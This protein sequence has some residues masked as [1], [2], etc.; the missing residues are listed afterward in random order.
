MD[1]QFY[2]VID[3]QYTGPF[4]MLLLMRKARKGELTPDTLL[5]ASKYETPH[6]ASDIPTINVFFSKQQEAPPPSVAPHQP[7]T[8]PIRLFPL[9]SKGANELSF[10]QSTA[11]FFAILLILVAG[12]LALFSQ[13]LAASPLLCFIS[14][15]TLT[16]IMFLCAIAL[17]QVRRHPTGIEYLNTVLGAFTRPYLIASFVIGTVSLSLPLI[18]ATAINPIFAIFVFLLSP[19]LAMHSFAPFYIVDHPELTPFEAMQRSRDAVSHAGT[20]SLISLSV[21]WAMIS[22]AYGT[23]ILG[24][25]FIPIA[26]TAL[27]EYYEENLAA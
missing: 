8:P 6:K 16:S 12:F 3:D 18:L 4:D 20:L 10:H 27:A 7:A 9:L 17:R 26:M 15:F 19:I 21:L 23:V 2:I 22:V 5:T 11:L 13:I 24:L 1:S 25:I 14:P